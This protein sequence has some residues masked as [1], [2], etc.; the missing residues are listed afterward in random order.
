MSAAEILVVN[1][2]ST[3]L[4]LDLVDTGEMLEIERAMSR[5]VTP[6]SRV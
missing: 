4:K 3:S 1:S 2:G 5:D 6:L